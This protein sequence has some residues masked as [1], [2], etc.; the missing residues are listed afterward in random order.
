MERTYGVYHSGV[1]IKHLSW[2]EDQLHV[3]FALN[4]TLSKHFGLAGGQS[5]ATHLSLAELSVSCE[6]PQGIVG[7]EVLVNLPGCIAP[8]RLK[9]AAM[10]RLA[11]YHVEAWL[12]KAGALPL[13]TD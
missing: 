4:E 6:A 2:V 13:K 11:L 9:K 3:E 12:R 5:W 7:D 10:D 8:L 1:E